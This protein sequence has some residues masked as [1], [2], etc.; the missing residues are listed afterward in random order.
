MSSAVLGLAVCKGKN[1]SDKDHLSIDWATKISANPGGAGP[2]NDSES[3]LKAANLRGEGFALYQQKRDAD[4]IRKY[5]AALDLYADDVIYYDYANSLSNIEGRLGDSIKAYEIGMAIS[6]N[7][8]ANL[9]YNLACAQ[10]RAGEPLAAIENL[11]L[12]LK[13][14]G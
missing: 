2:E 8:S 5:E 7:P 1:Y 11:R 13:R 14:I 9:Y 10:S 3:K 4:A 12:A 6:K